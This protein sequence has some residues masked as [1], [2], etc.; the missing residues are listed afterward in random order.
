M[1]TTTTTTTTAPT[2]AMPSATLTAL[3]QR[4]S[5]VA[6]AERTTEA[7]VTDAR[8]AGFNST[9]DALSALGAFL[10]GKSIAGKLTKSLT[11]ENIRSAFADRSSGLFVD[12][13]ERK[14][15]P[16]ASTMSRALA[17]HDNDSAA[18]REAFKSAGNAPAMADY[19]PWLTLATGSKLSNASTID[20]A[21]TVTGTGKNRKVGKITRKPSARTTTA[22]PVV[23]TVATTPEWGVLSL[24]SDEELSAIPVVAD[25]SGWTAEQ[26]LA[27]A[28]Q[29]V[30][31]IIMEERSQKSALLAITVSV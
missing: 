9:C 31:G 8:W 6:N 20:L 27:V 4:A 13:E 24:A 12:A 17:I 21:A 28:R 10:A 5:A 2:L 29:L 16:S 14:T 25:V 1:S 11:G 18:R 7:T 26:R 3:A 23:A 22:T 30:A 15:L 19:V